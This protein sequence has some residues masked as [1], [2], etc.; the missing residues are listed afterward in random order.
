METSRFPELEAIFAVTENGGIFEPPVDLCYD[1]SLVVTE[2]EK[3]VQSAPCCFNCLVM[4][5]V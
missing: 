4:V 3:G 5:R 2:D 1:Q